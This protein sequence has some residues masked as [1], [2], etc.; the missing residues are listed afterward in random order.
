MKKFVLI[1]FSTLFIAA[2]NLFAETYKIDPMHSDITFKIRHLM[3]SKVSGRFDQFSGEF[4]YDGKEPKNW[5]AQATIQAASINTGIA[6]RDKHLRTT[7]FFDAEK[8][9]T[10]EFKS[11]KVSDYDVK[12]GKAKLTGLLTL[13]GAS[14]E[15]TLDLDLGGTIKDPQG[16]MRAG[17]EATGKINRKDFGINYNKV[18]DT[19]GL[20]LGEEVE[21][22]IHVEGIIPKK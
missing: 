2:A 16:N 20:A 17:F 19:G 4:N 1:S 6:D 5:N 14:K 18:L 9:P 15:V 22:A 21:I 13:H 11:V 10:L 8:F 7:D 3:I 12:N